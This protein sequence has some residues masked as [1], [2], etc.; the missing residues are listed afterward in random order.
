MT[1]AL[2]PSL[3]GA[4]LDALPSAREQGPPALELVGVSK[5]YGTAQALRD[6]QFTIRPGEVVALLGPSGAGKSTVFRCISRLVEVDGGQVRVMGRDIASLNRGALR[7]QRRSIGL[8]FQQFNLIGRLSA[9]D[10]VL[11]GRLGHTPT[12]RVL[13]RMFRS[14]DRQI[15]LAALDRVGL[16]DRAYQRADS[17]SGGQQQRVAIARVLAQQ[18]KLILADEPVASLD[19]ASAENVLNVLREIARERGIA[20]L[21][22]LHQ[23]DL[24]RRYA[25]RI[26]ALRAGQ[27]VL[28]APAGDID[29]A[30]ID[31]IYHGSIDAPP[32]EAC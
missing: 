6:V 22:S 12:W 2:P 29:M 9:R 19:P 15:A 18:S 10:N 4:A 5:M 32:S 31:A 20:V 13:A 8:I 14:A 17:L 7:E 1:A 16:L 11:A 28:D 30:Q 3:R 26:V 27:V 21:C 25:D 23:T 24:A